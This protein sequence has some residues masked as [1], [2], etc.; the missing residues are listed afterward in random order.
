[1][2]EIRKRVAD[3]MGTPPYMVL[4]EQTL[5]QLAATKPTSLTNLGRVSGFTDVKIKSFG[6]EFIQEI[7]QYCSKNSEIKVD[8]F[9]T[10]EQVNDEIAAAGLTDTENTTL[11]MFN[12]M[13][14]YEKVAA[15]RGLKPTSI[16]SHL[17]S[18]LEKGIEVPLEQLG[19]T[20]QIV[21]IVVK[22]IWSSPISSNVARLS[23]IK[24]E[25]DMLWGDLN[26]DYSKLKLV[27]V[28]LKRE[29]GCSEEGILQWNQDDYQRYVISKKPVKT[30]PV[31]TMEPKETTSTPPKA[32]V[33]K[34]FKFTPTKS[35]LDTDPIHGDQENTRLEPSQNQ[36]HAK[37]VVTTK[38]QPAV[39]VT[40]SPPKK[41]LPEWLCNPEQRKAIMAKKMK[42]NSL[43]K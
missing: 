14:D 3:R 13:K 26:I 12:Q 6:E 40:T 10:V 31:R 2:V 4:R 38:L 37:T 11:Q 30:I 15:A 1:L 41:R 27:V 18:C 36:S 16:I 8:D 34:T 23:P 39:P 7:I 29:H 33:A 17:A 5:L 21:T 35:K 9:P 25:L 32:T 19:I 22:T 42:T 24:E 20:P 43:F 28:Q